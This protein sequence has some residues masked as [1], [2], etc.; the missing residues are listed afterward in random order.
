MLNTLQFLDS[1][2]VPYK[3]EGNNIGKGYLGL[4]VCPSCGDTRNHCGVNI[5]YGKVSCFICNHK[6]N[7]YEYVKWFTKDKSSLVYTKFKEAKVDFV[8]EQETT[9]GTLK[10][11]QGM[12][13]F[14]PPPHKQYLIDR[15]FD[16]D[17]LELRYHLKAFGMLNKRWQ[18]RIIVPIF[19]QNRI[20]SYLGRAIFD[21]I[22]PR[23]KNASAEDSIIP[24]KQCLYG[25]DE[26]G[27]H[28]VLVE[29]L[30]DAWRFGSGAVA[31]MGVEVTNKQI[32][33]I[34]KQ[35]VTR[36]TVLFDP[37]EAGEYAAR[38][39]SEKISLCGVDTCLFL[40]HK[41]SLVDVGDHS[42]DEIDVIRKEI[43]K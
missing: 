15:N 9:T 38:K 41:E 27:S 23:Y 12:V 6:S 29:G 3:R 36:V 18:Y 1:C 31:T 2:E 19:M 37:D 4:P 21:N 8:Y 28:V 20:V 17:F 33:F 25:L 43:F 26:V 5:Q 16:P 32:N 11:P 34:K 24:V 40:W 7:I 10:F 14:L 30:T 42:I 22:E 35:G 13:D 39:V